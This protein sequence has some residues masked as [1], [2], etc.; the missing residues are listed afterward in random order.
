MLAQSWNSQISLLVYWKNK[1][2]LIFIIPHW[3]KYFL[4]LKCRNGKCW[5]HTNLNDQKLI[6][7]LFRRKI[8]IITQF[9]P[10]IFFSNGQSKNVYPILRLKSGLHKIDWGG[11]MT[12]P[13]ISFLSYKF[14]TFD[15]FFERGTSSIIRKKKKI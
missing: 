1:T 6:F 13:S 3:K 10:F 14:D 11:G 12:P 5:L 15:T 9:N 7:F 4:S 2:T 8:N